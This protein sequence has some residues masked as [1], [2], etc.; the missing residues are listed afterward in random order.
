VESTAKEKQMKLD[1]EKKSE[2]KKETNLQKLRS[3]ERQDH[4]ENTKF[5]HHPAN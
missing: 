4:R 3:I 2:N 1:K 5:N